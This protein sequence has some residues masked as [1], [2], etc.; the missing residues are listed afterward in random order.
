MEQFY[1]SKSCDTSSITKT[2]IFSNLGPALCNLGPVKDGYIPYHG[3]LS[4]IVCGMGTLLNILNILVLTHRD[5]RSNPINLILTGIAV[6]DCLVMLEYIP[7]TLHMY[8]VDDADRDQEEK[9][10]LAWGFF[11]L[12]HNNFTIMIHTVSIWLT[13]SL[14]IWRLLMIRFPTMA[15]RL[16][17][18]RNCRTV[19]TLGY[20]RINSYP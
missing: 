5:M 9:Y 3:L 12:F 17:T 15:S 16:C 14:A 19:L 10:S 11:L 7:F 6:A 8:L 18:M 4:V 1:A 13:L 20:G 2:S